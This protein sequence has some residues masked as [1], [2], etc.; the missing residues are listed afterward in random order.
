MGPVT[1]LILAL[2]L[3]SCFTLIACMAFERRDLTD[4]IDTY[5]QQIEILTLT[6]TTLMSENT[7]LLRQKDTWGKGSRVEVARPR[8]LNSMQ[9]RRVNDQANAVHL[10]AEKRL[11]NSEILKENSDG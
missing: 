9:A 6:N 4:R 7:E 10:S 1:I 11:P 3:M 5:S 2:L 8:V